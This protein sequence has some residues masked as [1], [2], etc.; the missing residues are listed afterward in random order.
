MVAIA[1]ELIAV[2]RFPPIN[3]M[4]QCLDLL[5]HKR[6]R[7]PKPKELW[8]EQPFTAAI[9][10]FAEAGSAIGLSSSKIL[11]VLNY[12]LPQRA[13]PSV[14]NNFLDGELSLFFRG[15]ALK[16]VLLSNLEPD[17]EAL[18]PEK[19][20][21]NKNDYQK[22]Q[23]I[24]KFKQVVNALLPLYLIRSRVLL[25]SRE[26]LEILIEEENQRRSPG[27][28]E[29]EP[30]SFEAARVFFESLVL[31]KLWTS[32]E[33]VSIAAKFLGNKHK[34]SLND[35]L[36]AVRA[37]YRLEHLSEMRDQLEQS[38][39][40]LIE[41]VSDEGPEAKANYYIALARAVL[42]LSPEDA[43]AYF[44]C[45]IEAVSKF[46]DELVERWEAIVAMAKRSAEGGHSSPKTAYRFIRCAEL[47]GDS[48]AREKYWSRDEAIQVCAKLCPP[49]AFTALSRWRDRDV[50]WFERQLPALA[51]EVVHSKMIAPSVAWS[52]SAFSWNY[53]FA[54]FAASCIQTESDKTCRQY[55][56]DTAIRDLRLNDA[57]ESSWQSLERTAQQFSL[58][59]KEI[60]Q[61]L[62][63]YDEH[64]R[65]SNTE[66]SNHSS[67]LYSPDELQNI[68]WEEILGDLALPQDL[69]LSNAIAR[70][71]ALPYPRHHETFWKEVFRRVPV[72]KARNFLQALA[73]AESAD[74]YDI[75][76]ALG[77][78]P[79]SYRQKISVKQSWS[80]FFL[81]I[82]QRF[83]S[84]L[85]NR[86]IREDFIRGIQAEDSTKLLI[87]EG[88]IKRL[89]E[90]SDLVSASE[91][92]GFSE[93]VSPFISPQEA[94]K[95][96]E[97]ALSRFEIHIDQD[98]GD[99]PWDNWL[100]PPDNISEA[101]TGFVWA[102]LGSPRSA[103]RWQAAHCVR[104]L[105]EADCEGEID[106]LIEWMNQDCVNAFGSH[107][108]PFYN[109]HARLY[110]LIA[111]ARI[112]IDAP[113]KLRR[114]HPTFAYHALDGVPH[115]LIQKF[116]AEIALSIEATFP[117]TYDSGITDKLHRVGISQM[118]IK[119]IDVYREELEE[120]PWHTQGEVDH[121]L[122]LHFGWDFEQYWFKPLGRVFGVSGNQV[123][124]LAREVVLKEWGTI[125]DDQFKF[126]R[127]PR[128]SLWNSY[129]TAQEIRHSHGS[130]PRTDDYSFY[131]S[132]HAMLAVATKLLLDMPV[133]RTYDWCDDEWA[134]WLQRHTLAR[135]DGRWLAD[136][137][138]PDPL[139][140][141]TWLLEKTTENWR[142]D[143]N[144]DD[145]LNGLL[146][147]RN[148]KT[149]LNVRGSWS[150]SDSQRQETF[151]IT[152][153][154][155]SQ[156][157]SQSLLN[158]LSSCLNPHDFKLPDYQE[159]NMEFNESPFEL[160]GWIYRD[161]E[162]EGLDAADP[163]AGR[164]D[165]PPYRIGNSIADRLQLSVDLEQRTWYMPTTNEESLVCELWNL[166]EREDEEEAPRHGKRMSV[167][168]ESLTTICS[169]LERELVIEVQIQRR[170]RRSSYYS[171]S[172]GDGKYT[173]P[174]SKIYIFSTRG[175]LRDTRTCYQLR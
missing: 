45:A 33:K 143:L 157:T 102:A 122:E 150:D 146:T 52:L 27:Q 25:G 44:N 76:Y 147:K 61:V 104:R 120:T 2:G 21:E 158:A 9:I 1:D 170:L 137:R 141:C 94:G 87:Y 93:I 95:L 15:V 59:N 55:I 173:A 74:L 77:S 4:Q 121:N 113:D 12:Y 34:L 7:I 96:L 98:Y 22:N 159:E 29:H 163:H 103:I 132:Y 20:L 81:S 47:V 123:E 41:S 5:T 53:Q 24:E 130:Y 71:N 144:P 124:D 69:G 99:G 31:S 145:F 14:T 65:E 112:A 43:S 127:D 89:S 40:E 19:F 73:E 165:Y 110:L 155:V 90:S 62:D 117:G 38:C 26:N 37:A 125:T 57:P 42:P 60:R 84:K 92:F 115:A 171:G 36:R 32:S 72:S 114:H 161:S 148:D 86:Y 46:G 30:F 51:H 140:R 49:S 58:E 16:S 129:R 18:I 151:Y 172:D 160:Q 109:L 138:D 106:A 91:L 85:T 10:S 169:T 134:D 156:K 135:S 28:G 175:Q 164:I 23:D 3:A 133:V 6:A 13:A 116:A 107:T 111:L 168:L 83:A 100:F 108:F 119:E 67:Q 82:A 97:F 105:A 142:Q 8:R 54:E 118:P 79:D 136:R 35:Y 70:F 139:E 11:R 68:N 128:S 50:G 17:I 80:K 66:E 78:F 75:R 152:S 48:V 131:I 167:S 88:I 126:I 162:S 56:L 63:F 149:W 39:C 174:S 101:F 64:P 154:L 166:S 153:A